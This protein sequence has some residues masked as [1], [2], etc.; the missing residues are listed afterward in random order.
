MIWCEEGDYSEGFEEAFGDLLEVLILRDGEDADR[1][2]HCWIL[3]YVEVRCIEHELT[4]VHRDRSSDM[5]SYVRDER[6][7]RH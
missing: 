1:C 6:E 3:P 4:T 5:K 7:R 2:E